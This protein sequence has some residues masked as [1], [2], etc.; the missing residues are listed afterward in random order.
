MKIGMVLVPR[1]DS[2]RKW[3]QGTIVGLKV[4]TDEIGRLLVNVYSN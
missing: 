2:W 3:L 1:R 4:L